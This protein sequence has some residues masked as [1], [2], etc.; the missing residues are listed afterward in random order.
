M[1][2]SQ[3]IEREKEYYKQLVLKGIPFR[4]AVFNVVAEQSRRIFEKG[5]NSN[6]GK[7]GD[8]NSSDDMYVYKTS[9]KGGGKLGVTRGKPSTLWKK[10]NNKYPNGRTKHDDGSKYKTRWLSSYKDLRKKLDRP[11]EFVNLKMNYDLFS[12]FC[13][14]TQGASSAIPKPHKINNFEYQTKWTRKLNALKAAG[15]EKH[16]NCKIWNTTKKEKQLFLKTLDFNIRKYREEFYKE[17]REMPERK[18]T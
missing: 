4:F 15:L 5:L 14:A 3:Y 16:F 18:S 6:E 10:P 17:N 13:N 8:Y 9:F 1:S 11:V 2:P 7:I 12:D